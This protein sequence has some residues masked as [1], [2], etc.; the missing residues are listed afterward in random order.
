MN[1]VTAVLGKL[2]PGIWIVAA[3]GLAWH[4]LVVVTEVPAF[5][6]PAP[7][8]VISTLFHK[9]G[10]F[11]KHA[12]VTAFEIIVGLILGCIL[13]ILSAL[14]PLLTLWLGY[15]MSSKI[16]MAVL[17]IYF[18]VVAASFDGLRHTPDA[19]LQL[20]RSMN[21]SPWSIIRHIRLPAAL[22]SIASGV[23]VAT[24]VAPIGAVIG[25]WVGSSQGLGFA[26]LNA[27]G[28]MQTDE[29]FAALF[30]L[31]ILAVTLYVIVNAM[32]EKCLSW[33]SGKTDT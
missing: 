13:G 9:F 31:C 26:M 5:I 25:E 15:G 28:R 30:C 12:S 18:P 21:A 10:Y 6:F 33:H 22:P 1:T 23:R 24:S 16:A 2:Q 20:A 4:V 32:L 17:I 3:I 29:M 27:N 8:D 7:L 11:L 19:M 14:A